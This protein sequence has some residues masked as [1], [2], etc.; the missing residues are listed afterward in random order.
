MVH[1]R[2]RLS[3]LLFFPMLAA[4]ITACAKD[5]VKASESLGHRDVITGLHTPWEILWGPDDWLWVTER[6]GRISRVNPENGEQVVVGTINDVEETSESGLLGMAL[7]QQGGVTNV[8][9][10]YTYLNADDDL[11]ERLVRY[12]YNGTALVNPQELLSNIPA[13]SNH[14][15]SRLVIVG[16][17]LFMTT[18]DAQDGSNAQDLGSVAGKVLRMNLD[19]TAPADNPWAGMSSPT[20]LIWTLGHRNAQGLTY[21]PNGILYASEHGPNSD[22]EVNIIEKG[23]NYG[24]PEVEGFCNDDGEKEFCTDSNVFEPM[25]AWTPTLAVCGLEYYGSDAVSPWRNGLLM[26]SLKEG[27]LRLLKLS[28]DGRTIAEENIYYNEEWGRLRDLCVAPDGRVFVGTSNRDG[29]GDPRDGDD[30]IMELN[31]AGIDG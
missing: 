18:G 6:N 12:D 9:V 24:W 3:L 4:A 1:T 30:R 8:Y 25:K 26:V 17:K 2:S 20:N 5:P 15:G 23:R 7:H 21:A 27:D 31:T 13:N 14:N 16:D 19:G 10:V 29:R 22:D 11:R 28:A